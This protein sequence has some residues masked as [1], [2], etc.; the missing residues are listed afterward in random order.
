MSVRREHSTMLR[1]ALFVIGGVLAAALLANC[2]GDDGLSPEEYFAELEGIASERQEA[3]VANSDDL[4]AVLDDP[5]SR[6]D[7]INEAIRTSFSETVATTNAAISKIEALS[8]PGDLEGLHDTF[9]A[10]LRVS[11]SRIQEFA[12]R[13]NEA[14]DFEEISRI[15][16]SLDAEF[17]DSAFT[18]AC[19]ALERAGDEAGLSVDLSCDGNT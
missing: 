6:Q 16:D 5:D 14:E 1:R 9:I 18:A 13:V 17:D 11:T 7:D 3:S 10:E 4:V 15:I 12:E 8:P 19:E 2:G